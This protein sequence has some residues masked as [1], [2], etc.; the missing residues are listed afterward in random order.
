[1]R[2]KVTIVGAGNTGA[3]MAQILAARG[4]ADIVLI[5]IVEGLPQGKALDIAE[6]APWSRTSSKILGTNDWA[7]TANSE[8]V[9]VTSGVARKPGMTREDL[10]GTNAGIVR[11][12]VGSAA[13]ASP[14]ATLIIFANPMDAMCHV[15]LEASGFPSTRVV[16]QGGMLDSTRYRTFISMATGASVKDVSAWVLGGHTEA[17]MVPIVSNAT[18]GGVPLAKLLSQAEI[19]AVVARTQR[20]GAEIVDLLKTGSAFVAPAVATIEMVDAILLDE[21]RI[22]PCCTYLKGEFGVTDGYVGVPVLLGAGGIQKIYDIKVSDAE[23]AAIKVAGDA[24][25]ELVAATP[26]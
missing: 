9:I 7:D 8:V 10:L 12:V 3:T 20:G 21:K 6:A 1:M 4:Y 13:K 22:L 26:K 5:D 11:S 25:K 23:A 18:V 16:G 17:T 24:V 14:N 19:D 15:A 2:Q